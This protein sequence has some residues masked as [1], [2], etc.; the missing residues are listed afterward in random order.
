M[1]SF[2]LLLYVLLVLTF[3]CPHRQRRYF[4]F[5]FRMVYVAV[6]ASSLNDFVRR[7]RCLYASSLI[8][9][10]HVW[11]YIFM[12][13]TYTTQF[14]CCS[15]SLSPS[16]HFVL[17]ESCEYIFSSR[18]WTKSSSSIVVY[19]WAG[20]FCPYGMN[21]LASNTCEYTY[22][23]KSCKWILRGR[24]TYYVSGKSKCALKEYKIMR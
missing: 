6:C 19:D 15:I 10:G 1:T 21:I 9:I 16:F 12:Q 24:T 17:F 3:R 4:F 8:A 20:L 13:T 11:E 5:V 18:T 23:G 2:V 14:T 22:I 7:V